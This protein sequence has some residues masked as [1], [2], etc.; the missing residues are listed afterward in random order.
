MPRVPTQQTTVRVPAELLQWLRAE[1][2]RSERSLNDV[3]VRGLR[4]YRE[5]VET[6]RFAVNAAARAAEV[7][8]RTRRGPANGVTP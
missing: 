7:A 3:M 6:E 2:D 5:K 4:D 8:R 1:A